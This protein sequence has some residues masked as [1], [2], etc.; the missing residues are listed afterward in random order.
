VSNSGKAKGTAF[1]RHSQS[2]PYGLFLFGILMLAIAVAGTCMGQIWGR[3]GQSVYRNK[4]PKAFWLGISAYC[5]SGIGLIGYYL[6]LIRWFA[7]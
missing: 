4:Q 7:D 2:N 5:V 3:S 1:V 6:Y